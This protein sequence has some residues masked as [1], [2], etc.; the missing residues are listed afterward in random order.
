MYKSYNMQP[1]AEH[2][3][4]PK[5]I[6]WTSI[7]RGRAL[8]RRMGGGDVMKR[9]ND[10]GMSILLPDRHKLAERIHSSLQHQPKTRNVLGGPLRADIAIGGSRF[11]VLR[12][13]GVVM[14]LNEMGKY[15]FV[16]RVLEHLMN[17]FTLSFRSSQL[18]A[19]P[20]KVRKRPKHG[21]GV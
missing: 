21:E 5:H 1:F 12:Q 17:L 18:R 19:M 2:R 20:S 11:V 8:E 16:L 9:W 3:R 14:T 15:I 10:K 6:W 7:R 13:G 4:R